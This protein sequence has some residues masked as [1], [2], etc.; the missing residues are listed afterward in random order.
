MAK[1]EVYRI[2]GMHCASCTLA[3]ERSLSRLGVE[4]SVSLA[5][6]EA[7]VRYDPSRVRPRDIV[8]S[9]RKAG[10]DVYKEELVARVEGLSSYD[11][12][13]LL[14]GLLEDLDGVIR[15]EAS[16]VD[17]VVRVVFNP[18]AVS[19]AEIVSRIE[20][21]GYRVEY[22][23][24]EARVEDVGSKTAREELERL[25]RLVILSLPPALFL[26]IYYMLGYSGVWVPL[27][28]SGILRD[29]AI[30]L[31]L[32]TLVLAVGSLRFL[33]PAIR[34][35]ANLSPGMDA[36]VILG[37]YSAYLF[38]IA[39]SL[40]LVRGES[41]YEASSIVMAF[42][43]LG[44]YLETRLKVMTGEAV[45]KL[46]ELQARRARV[47][48]NGR[49]VEIPVEEVRIKDMVLVKPGEKIPVDG[50][51]KEGRGF[52]D[53]SAMTGE[54]LPVEKAEGDPV[55][56][57]TVLVR[58]SLVIST[59]RVG[60]DTV[61][62]QVIRLVRIAQSSRPRI[63]RLADKISGIFTWLVI[64]VAAST[65]AYWSAVARAP[66]DLAIIFTASV[67]VVA[68]PCA[69][70]L[71]TPTAIVTGFGRAAQMGIV[72]KDAEAVERVGRVGTIVLDKT[73]TVTLGRPSVRAV[74]PLDSS[75]S[76]KEI[77][78]L[79]AIAEKR[80]EHPLAL[81]VLERAREAGIEVQR[82]P[83]FFDSLPGQGV[84]ASVDGVTVAVGNEKLMK[85]LDVEN[86]EAAEKAAEELRREGLTAVYVASGQTI[87]GVLGIGDTPRP[88]A[89]EVI[90]RLKRRGYRVV[91]LTGDSRVTA[92][93][94]GARLG[95]DDVVAEVSPEEKAEVVDRLRKSS[96]VAMVGDG[97]NDAAALSK[98]DL[99]IAMGGGADIARE[100]GHVVLVRG[101]LR[102]VLE[103]LEILGGVRRKIGQNL[104]W[105]FVYNVIL[106]PLAAGALY[107]L[108][109]VL[110]P[111]MA[112]AAMA[113]SSISVTLSSLS[114]G[115]L[116]RG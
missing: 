6:E 65:F 52:V 107:S 94:L 72:I 100:A 8:D 90:G 110:R 41:F 85:G 87:L 89:A 58:G 60:K 48:R 71:A 95:F 23:E 49:E 92:E 31:P 79:A 68:C 43:L 33:R 56:A 20:G 17:G 61:L 77:L 59:T 102:G 14:V 16:H 111:E 26:G 112:G 5:S 40:G 76:E 42:I 29:L 35:L 1:E 78:A 50:V 62:G 34:S 13:R 66:L 86:L 82:D 115:R 9:V 36:L 27:W 37:T 11:D 28:G 18:L 25:E 19:Q 113:L 83:E 2:L 53:E 104:F 64:A 22:V 88:E 63:Q 103:T 106:I 105:A 7:R 3:L 80:S 54:P 44:R 81:A 24:A 67:L 21:R 45:R 108:G 75:V 98:A 96:G 12:E 74:K 55:Y 10:Y 97:I 91:M 47:V 93:A 15:A 70:G 84:L 32:S 57:G 30:G 101:D 109:I 114:L 39:T 69:L 116:G 73:G 99:G 51:V 4:A 38:S 46:A